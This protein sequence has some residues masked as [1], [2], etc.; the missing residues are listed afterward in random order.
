MAEFLVGKL[1][2][3]ESDDEGLDFSRSLSQGF[4]DLDTSGI[5]MRG[6][7]AI[8]QA[9]PSDGKTVTRNRFSWA[10]KMQIFQG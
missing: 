1:K 3:L 6:T 2:T 9:D 5:S 8:D 10:E 4:A 7:D